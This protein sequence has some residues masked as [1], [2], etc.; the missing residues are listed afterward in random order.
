METTITADR[1]TAP[2]NQ[3]KRELLESEILSALHRPR[4]GR[5]LVEITG[6]AFYDLFEVL[7]DLRE[8]GVISSYTRRSS[9][10]YKLGSRRHAP[11]ENRR[12]AVEELKDGTKTTAELVAALRITQAGVW[13]TLKPLLESGIVE[14][15]GF[16]RHG[17]G[18]PTALFRLVEGD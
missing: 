10:Y 15:S 14:K 18:R 11:G 6:R 7:D 13:V 17:R 5:Q 2:A 1:A 8:R 4:T 12:R 16:V 3:A 9:V